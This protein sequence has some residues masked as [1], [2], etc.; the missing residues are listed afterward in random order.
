MF[1][2]VMVTTDRKPITVDVK[3]D[4]ISFGTFAAPTNELQIITP[5]Y[6]QLKFDFDSSP[7]KVRRRGV[8]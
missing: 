6:S 2:H 1:C 8:W 4:E 5:T 7:L 3:V